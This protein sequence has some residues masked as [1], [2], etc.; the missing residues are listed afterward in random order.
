MPDDLPPLDIP[1][2]LT[3][4]SQTLNLDKAFDRTTV[5]LYHYT[6]AEDGTS[7]RYPGQRLV[8]IKASISTGP[9]PGPAVPPLSA[10]WEAYHGVIN[11]IVPVKRL[12]V[13]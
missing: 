6:S 10:I 2:R 12:V 5:T 9:T 3:G 1:W 4:S 13:D 8:H 11:P 7:D